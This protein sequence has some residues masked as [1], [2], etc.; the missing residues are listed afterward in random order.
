MSITDSLKVGLK[1]A[2]HD[3]TRCN[4]LNLLIENEKHDAVC[5]V[6]NT[7]IF[8]VQGK[9]NEAEKNAIASLKIAQE[10]G[11][12]EKIQIT[13]NTL[14]H[15]Y[16][17]QNKGM[18]AFKMHKLYIVMRDRINRINSQKAL[19]TQNTKYEKKPLLIT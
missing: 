18:D 10:I 16:E 8:I 12:P 13:P 14:Y 17:K 6:N 3:A 11:A 7:A 4:I 19:I 15:I 1:N 5:L 2:N 9:I